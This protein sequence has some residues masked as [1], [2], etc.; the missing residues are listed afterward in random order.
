MATIAETLTRFKWLFFEKGLMHVYDE[1]KTFANRADAGDVAFTSHTSYGQVILSTPGTLDVDV[2]VPKY[3][4]RPQHIG[5]T[6][7]A[8][9]KG[10]DPPVLSV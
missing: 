3:V 1:L 2:A 5:F 8:G 10:S 9:L 7:A 6:G 4:N